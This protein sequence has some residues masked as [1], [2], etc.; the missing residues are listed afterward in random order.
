MLNLLFAALARAAEQQLSEFKPQNAANTAWAFATANHRD[1]K[2]F[3]DLAIVA[4][5]QLSEFKP[6]EV[7]NTACTFAKAN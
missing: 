4:E 5:R 3:A 6:L 7:A 1:E 2:L